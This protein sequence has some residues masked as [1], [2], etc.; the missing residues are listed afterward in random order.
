MLYDLGYYRMQMNTMY[1]DTANSC[2][3]NNRETF[4]NRI[5]VGVNG[6]FGKESNIERIVDY[7]F[8]IT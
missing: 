1:L 3:D 4:Q 7:D 2:V 8:R 5:T 6:N